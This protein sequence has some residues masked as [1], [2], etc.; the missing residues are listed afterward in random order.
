LRPPGKD[1]AVA[2]CFTAVAQAVTWAQLDEPNNFHGGRGLNS[3]LSFAVTAALAWRRRAPLAAVSWAVAV[4]CLSDVVVRHDVAALSSFVPLIVLTAAAGYH[5][6]RRQAIA[7]AA[8]AAVGLTTVVLVEPE[9]RSASN[10]VYDLVFLLAP[11]LAGRGLR[12]REDRASALG[13]DLERERAAQ[14][15]ARQQVVAAERVRI[16]REL[17]D[18]VAHSVAVMVIQLGAARMNLHNDSEAAE[19]SLL[20]A[21]D[22]GRQ[23]LGELRRLLEVLRADDHPLAGNPGVVPSPPQP[24]LIQLPALVANA[25]AT[26][27]EVRLDITGEPSMPPPGLDLTAY[28]IIQEAVTNSLKHAHATHIDVHLGYGRDGL[29]ID[30]TDDGEGGSAPGP[31]TGHG[32]VGIQERVA[33]FGGVTDA[34][35]QPGGGWRVHAYLPF[36]GQEPAQAAR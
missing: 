35:L 1:V 30:V 12:E 18:V 34:R 32:L 17:H 13:A 6:G 4:F 26:G 14:E 11:W 15:T 31:G 24:G 27:V 21:E 3:A 28:R 2:V 7:A 19:C 33:V 22:V 29:E 9:L 25:R 23:A 10:L 20:A 36:A 8:V 5:A 16:A